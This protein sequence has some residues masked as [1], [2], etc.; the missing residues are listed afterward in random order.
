MVQ[1]G[2][3]TYFAHVDASDSIIARTV[4]N[5][6]SYRLPSYGR[7]LTA[8]QTQYWFGIPRNV[9]FRSIGMDV[10]YLFQHAETKDTNSSS[11]RSNFIRQA[12]IAG[13][14]S[15]HAIPEIMFRAAGVRPPISMFAPVAL[16]PFELGIR[17]VPVMSVPI[18]LP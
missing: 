8:A 4:G 18:K 15:E 5:I 9:S 2:I 6:T 3:L 16:I 17:C 10:D 7:F 14:F 13:S 1:M 12:G 11:A